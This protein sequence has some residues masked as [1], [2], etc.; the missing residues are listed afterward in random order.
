[1]KKERKLIKSFEKET[2]FGKSKKVIR[3]PDYS[4]KE[5]GSGNNYKIEK[6]AST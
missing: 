4:I 1:M 6:K 3:S 5:E 2:I